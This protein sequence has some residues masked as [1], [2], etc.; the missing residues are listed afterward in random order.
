M[1]GYY[2]FVLGIIPVSLIAVAG[3]LMLA[4]VSLTLAVPAGALVSLVVI[5]HAMFVRVP[6]GE[7]PPA[8]ERT[9]S[10]ETG[11]SGAD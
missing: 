4:G 10:T 11:F 7:E 1:A 2:D 9:R 6:G 3:S 5:G 8:D